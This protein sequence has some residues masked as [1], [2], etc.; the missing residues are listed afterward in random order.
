MS[1]AVTAPIAEVTRATVVDAL[2]SPLVAHASAWC[3]PNVHATATWLDV[4][5]VR[6]PVAITQVTRRNSYV[7]SA[8]GQYLDYALEETRRVPSPAAR[9]GARVM[10]GALSP[11]LRA[12]DP[13]VVVDALP[14]STVLHGDRP[15][16]AWRD[17]LDAARERW[18]HTPRLVRSLD[19]VTG[20][21]A[22][23]A[24]RLP[25][26]SLMPSRLVFHQD[27]RHEAFWRARNL[28][29]DHALQASEPLESRVLHPGDAAEIQRLYW[30]LYGDKHSTLNPDFTV[31]W[32]AQAMRA[33]VFTGA[34]L[35]HGGRLAAA[36]LSYRVQG[37]MTNP[38]FGYDTALPQALGLYRR[39]SLLALED[40]R[41]RGCLLHASSGAPG[42]KA[43][44]GGVPAIEYHAVDLRGVRG[45]QRAAWEAALRIAGA[46][47]PAMLR[48]AT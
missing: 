3:A 22:M 18:P 1:E 28:R 16:A 27:P 12:L 30:L 33:G 8:T 37:V 48:R 46:V 42:F 26:V 13:V 14:V 38:V 6:W 39:L 41:A 17:A 25:G 32:L 15:A 11:M 43:S 31:P 4:D 21:A 7:V 34:G 24:L 47:G 10:L 29:H 19:G 45:V 9:A 2:W 36:Y 44:R 35:L 20:A 5:G 23:A 40:A